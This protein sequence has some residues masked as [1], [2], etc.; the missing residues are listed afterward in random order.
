MMHIWSG[1]KAASGGTYHVQGCLYILKL[2]AVVLISDFK[3]ELMLS[4]FL[5]VNSAIKMSK[6]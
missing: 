3:H 5:L 1:V 4:Y 2:K 6:T